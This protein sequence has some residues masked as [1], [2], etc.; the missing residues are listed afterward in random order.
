MRFSEYVA[1]NENVSLKDAIPWLQLIYFIAHDWNA[2]DYMHNVLYSK[3]QYVISSLLENSIN[4]DVIQG[5]LVYDYICDDEG[6]PCAIDPDTEEFATVLNLD[7][8][9]VN[10]KSL[11]NHVVNDIGDT[12]LIPGELLFIAGIEV[13]DKKNAQDKGEEKGKGGHH[14]KAV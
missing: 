2:D 5:E 7:R 11:I 6:N 12:S 1:R 4:K 8:S 13:P 3:R 9:H 14:E 10:M